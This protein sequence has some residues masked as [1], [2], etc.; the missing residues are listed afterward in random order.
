CVPGLGP[1]NDAGALRRSDEHAEMRRHR[2]LVVRDE[3]AAVLR[4]EGQN[5]RIGESR[6]P[7]ED[8]TPEVD[9]GKPS[10]R[11][12]N[13]DVV[14]ISVRLEADAHQRT[15]GVCLFASASFW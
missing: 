10:D 15:I 5:L 3:D 1:Y 9:L 14:K 6:Q 7:R 13:D 4:G 8:G 11:R 2:R 12:G